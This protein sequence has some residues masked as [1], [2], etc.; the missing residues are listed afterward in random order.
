MR[1]IRR[2]PARR[3]ACMRDLLN[4][5]QYLDTVTP[6]DYVPDR[7]KLGGLYLQA[8]RIALIVL[9]V[10]L[11][12]IAFG[13]FSQVM[14]SFVRLAQSIVSAPRRQYCQEDFEQDGERQTTS[15]RTS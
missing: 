6:V 15:S 5:L 10:C 14:H 8:I 9:A 13:F 1:D 11:V 7:P 4:D 3:Y 12:I 2:D